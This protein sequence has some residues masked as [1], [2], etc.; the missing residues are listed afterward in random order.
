M[1]LNDGAVGFVDRGRDASFYVL[2]DTIHRSSDLLI[3]MTFNPEYVDL[4]GIDPTDVVLHWGKVSEVERWIE[5][6]L[7]EFRV[8]LCP[9]SLRSTAEERLFGAGARDIRIFDPSMPWQF[10]YRT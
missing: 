1:I 5:E 3:E 6:F 7:I 8:E 10:L 2:F 4:G 9:V